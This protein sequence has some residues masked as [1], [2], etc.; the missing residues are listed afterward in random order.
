[1]RLLNVLSMLTATALLVGGCTSAY[2]VPTD[3]GRTEVPVATA[4]SSDSGSSG[5]GN[6]GGFSGSEIP[7]STSGDGYGDGSFAAEQ[8]VIYFEFDRSDIRGQYNRIIAEHAQYMANNPQVVARLE[9]HADERGSR[10]YNIG[11]GER[12]AQAVRQ[13]L[14]LQG[15]SASQMST[16]SFGEERPNNLGDNE[17]AWAQNRRV[18]IV[19]VR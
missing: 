12:R 3:D 16:V 10:E 18:E 6:D 13:A 14:R 4:P 7:A 19:Y 17:E 9:G 11:L 2:E 5:L 15:A 8:N 1:M